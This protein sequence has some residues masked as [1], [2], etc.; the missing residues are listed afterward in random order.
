MRAY[1]LERFSPEHLQL[2]ELDPP[3]PGVA[4]IVLER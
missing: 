3:Q 4:S 1:R 2:E